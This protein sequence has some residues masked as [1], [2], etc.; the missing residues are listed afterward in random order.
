MRICAVSIQ[1]SVLANWQAIF[2]IIKIMAYELSCIALL[3]NGIGV[4]RLYSINMIGV[5]SLIAS[6]II[7][8]IKGVGIS[9]NYKVTRISNGSP[10]IVICH[11]LFHQ[12][13]S[14]LILIQHFLSQKIIEAYS[15]PSLMKMEIEKVKYFSRVKHRV[16]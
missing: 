6:I 1:I 11:T 14:F 7:R 3:R 5:T 12:T 10:K 15:N 9:P 16:A 8:V 13:V 4:L 2:L